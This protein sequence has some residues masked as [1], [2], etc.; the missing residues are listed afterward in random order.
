MISIIEAIDDPRLLG[1]AIKDP[2]SYWAW[3]VLM[4][5][6]FGLPMDPA[7]LAFYEACTGRADAPTAA[8]AVLWLVIGR[9]GGKSFWMALTACYMALFKDW[10]PF[11]SPG[12]RAVV[13]LVAAD[14]EQAKVIRR[15]IGGI[16]E[17]PAFQSYV[18]AETTDSLELSGSVVIE[19]ATC[20]YRTVRGRS[21]CVALLDEVAF[22]RSDSSVNPDK[23]VWRAIRASMASF[24][25]HG[26]AII[27]SSPYAKRGLLYDGYKRYFGKPDARNLVWQAGTKLMNPT[28]SDD[29]LAEE[30]EADPISFA[31]EYEAQFRS[32]VSGWADLA[33]IEDCVDDGVTVRPPRPGIQY[34]AGT[35]PSGGARD[36][37][38][39][40]VAHDEDGTSVLDCVIEIRAPFDPHSATRDIAAT[41]KSYGI[42]S[43]TGDKYAA[44]WTI[45]AFRDCG[46][47]YEHSPR[48]RSAIY[49][50]VLPKFTSGRVRLLDNRRLVTQFA[51]LERK[52]SISGKDRVD[53][54]VGGFDDLCNSAALALV[55]EPVGFDMTQ[56]IKAWS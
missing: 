25:S 56:Y 26:L 47:E 13:L 50:D 5:A 30:Q 15:Y 49:L 2:A 40:A 18:E 34:R 28:I 6:V 7:D 31:C 27:G 43:V 37:F 24:G 19:V 17:A 3:R 41:L 22:Y 53:H 54:G 20:S 4:K 23:E 36:S 11:L 21:V 35:D 32:D 39:A 52:T 55:G 38:T 46:I 51:G 33:L 48:D 16:L 8:F 45:G 44:G 12:E 10:R 42:T 1:S 14:R 29:F 9:R